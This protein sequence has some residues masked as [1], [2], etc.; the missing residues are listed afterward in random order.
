VGLIAVTGSIDQFQPNNSLIAGFASK[1]EI[2]S[3]TKVRTAFDAQL[4]RIIKMKAI[5]AI[6][7][8]LILI[9]VIVWFG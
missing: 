5:R 2:T 4:H 9:G 1:I 3:C 6:D 8:A 7:I